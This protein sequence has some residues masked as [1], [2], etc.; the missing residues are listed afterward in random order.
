MSGCAGGATN[1]LVL[2][3]LYVPAS[4]LMMSCVLTGLGSGGV[5][6]RAEVKGAAAKSAMAVLAMCILSGKGTNQSP[7]RVD[8]SLRRTRSQSK[9][10]LYLSTAAVPVPL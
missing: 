10:Q 4:A 1:L 2:T 8:G 7:V 9:S 3:S 5:F 6:G